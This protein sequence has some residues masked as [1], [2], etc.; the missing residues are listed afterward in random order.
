MYF[1]A[2]NKAKDGT[3]REQVGAVVPAHVQWV[4]Q[5]LDDGVLLQAGAWGRGGGMLIA[6]A[7][8]EASAR[9]LLEEDPL[10]AA[11]LV[12]VEIGEFFPDVMSVEYA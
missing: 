5:K 6:K 11:G 8:D 12:N 2:I 1:L 10:V 3:T 9:Q 4:K 7:G